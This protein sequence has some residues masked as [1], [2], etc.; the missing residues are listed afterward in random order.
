LKD[1]K[2][3]ISSLKRRQITLTAIWFQ[4]LRKLDEDIYMNKSY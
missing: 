3:D 2:H 1:Y 4:K